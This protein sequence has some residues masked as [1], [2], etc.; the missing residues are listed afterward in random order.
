MNRLQAQGHLRRVVGTLRQSWGKV[1]NDQ[2]MQV[3]GE[4][5]K[6]MGR[7]QAGDGATRAGAT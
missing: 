3:R 2:T 4:H 5:D 1:I 6:L 7:L